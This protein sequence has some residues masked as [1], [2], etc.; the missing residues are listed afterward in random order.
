MGFLPRAEAQVLLPVIAAHDEAGADTRVKTVITLAPGD[1]SKGVMKVSLPEA[2]SFAR[3][4]AACGRGTCGSG[5][6]TCGGA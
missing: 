2:R 6:G 4:A 5:R 3:R 1:P